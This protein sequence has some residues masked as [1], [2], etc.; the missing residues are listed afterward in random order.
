MHNH[1]AAGRSEAPDVGGWGT[2]ERRDLS[3]GCQR[4]KKRVIMV[5][6]VKWVKWSIVFCSCPAKQMA[7]ARKMAKNVVSE[8]CPVKLRA[9]MYQAK[10][11]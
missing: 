9:S 2:R 8:S 3:S 1:S 6:W 11:R 4:V 10:D 5:N 7:L